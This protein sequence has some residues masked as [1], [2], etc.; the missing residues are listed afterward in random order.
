MGRE[1][2]GGGG[3]G[4]GGSGPYFML[5]WLLI[6]MRTHMH[7]CTGINTT[8]LE[9]FQLKPCPSVSFDQSPLNFNYL[10]CAGEWNT[11]V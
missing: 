5:T 2:G 11:T 6:H 3:W 10:I 8:L 7:I 1:W 4:G 9:A